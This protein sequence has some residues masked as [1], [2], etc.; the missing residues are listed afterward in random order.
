MVSDNTPALRLY[1]RCGFTEVRRVPLKP[2]VANDRTEWVEDPDF[3][4][5]ERFTCYMRR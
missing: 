1:A 5:A 3:A 4:A 2:V